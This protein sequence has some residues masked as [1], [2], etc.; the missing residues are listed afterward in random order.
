MGLICIP[1]MANEFEH[2]FGCFLAI[3]VSCLQRCLFKSALK[4]GCM[5][6][7]LRPNDKP[8]SAGPGPRQGLAPSFEC[9][10][11][12]SSAMA[13]P[14]SKQQARHCASPCRSLYPDCHPI[15]LCIAGLGSASERASLFPW[16]QGP[17]LTP[18]PR[19]SHFYPL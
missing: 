10:C 16:S 11:P 4:V 3:C 8:H 5:L 13:K 7:L 12:H 19:P 14:T 18:R 1:L 6:P 15:R 9:I 17:S 2:L